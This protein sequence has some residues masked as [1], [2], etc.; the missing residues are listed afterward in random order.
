MKYDWLDCLTYCSVL[1][2]WCW[3]VVWALSGDSS[4]PEE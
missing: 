1:A 2:A 4:S 3:A